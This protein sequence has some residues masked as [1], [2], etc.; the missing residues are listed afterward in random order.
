MGD[1]RILSFSWWL[2]ERA[3]K[4][5]RGMGEQ[6]ME[7]SDRLEIPEAFFRILKDVWGFDTLRESQREAIASILA[8]RDTLVVMPTGGGKSLCFQAPALYRGGLT[9]VVSPLIALMKDQV[10]ALEQVGAAAARIDSSLGLDEKRKIA[11]RISKG[12]IRLLFV[13]PERLIDPGF[14]Q[15]VQGNDVHTIA[16]DEAHCVSQWGHDFRPEYRKLSQIRSLFPKAAVHAFTATATQKVRDDIVGQLQLRSPRI[17]VNSFDRPNLTYRVL[18]QV[19]VVEQVREV[20]DRYRGQGG[21]IYCLRRSDV[22]SLC[23]ILGAHGYSVAPYHAGLSSDERKRAQEAFINETVDVVVATVAFGMG[24]DR[25]N[26]R[27]VVHTSMPKTVEHYQ[28]ETGRAGR[29]GL[30]SECILLFSLGD[31]VSL[32]RMTEA[33]L[34]EAG[35]SEELIAAQRT[36]LEEMSRYCRTPMCRHRGLAEYFG[37]TYPGDSCDA[38]DVCLG[39]TDNVP[40]AKIVSQK[41]LSC[42]HR[43]GERYGVNYLVDVLTGS[44]S[45]DIQRRGHATLSTYGILKDVSKSQLK[46]WIYQLV[47]QGAVDLEGDEYPIL[48]LNAHSREVLFGKREPRLLRSA[49]KKEKVRARASA[50]PDDFE[51]DQG[52]FD[53]LRKVRRD[54]AA[55]HSVPPY[56]VFS[57]RVLAEL[58]ARRPSNRENLLRCSG[59]GETK[60]EAYGSTFLQAIQ[61]YCHESN[62]PQDVEFAA[63]ASAP[64]EAKPMGGKPSASKGVTVPLLLQRESLEAVAAKAQLTVGTVVTHLLGLIEAGEIESIDPWVDPALQLRILASA[65]R[66]GRERLKPIFEDLEQSVPYDVLRIVMTFERSQISSS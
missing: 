2:R 4:K 66:L 35:A 37:E 1:G 13:S 6:R 15:L 14:A 26:V 52:L 24:I 33:S 10:D 61:Q 63:A 22:E 49:V 41:I 44:Q 38:C 31:M 20:L 53:Q 17:L 56:I 64:R 19:D 18:P 16:I 43:V 12:E 62:M 25:S 36:Q 28:Q 27:F 34:R 45:A 9:I 58:S 30:P 51:Y 39:D 32:R 46:D 29:D 55:Q 48:K 60:A 40:D 5:A 54:V 21:I 47:G 50:L 8:G 59:I 65:E 42:V 3:G 23:Q 7:S 57:D 11:Q